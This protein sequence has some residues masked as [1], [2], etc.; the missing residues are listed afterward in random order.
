M[1]LICYALRV[2]FA[3]VV[4]LMQVAFLEGFV[5]PFV[6]YGEGFK[7]PPKMARLSAPG[8]PTEA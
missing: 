8:S 3:Q 1:L 7:P 4:D 5:L 6:L 2:I